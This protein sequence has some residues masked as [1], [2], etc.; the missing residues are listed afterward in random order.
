MKSFKDYLI[1]GRDAPLYHGTDFHSAALIIQT[2]KMKATNRHYDGKGN[3]VSMTRNMKY[4][5]RFPLWAGDAYDDNDVVVFEL[6]QRKLAQRYKIVSFAFD[7]GTGRS[8]AR[9]PNEM[10]EFEERVYSNIA[11]I[12]NFITKIY[13]KDFKAMKKDLERQAPDGYIPLLNNWK[14]Y[15]LKTNKF[16]NSVSKKS[17]D[18]LTALKIKN[19]KLDHAMSWE[20]G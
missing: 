8:M 1:E 4:A 3:A 6:D 14:L 11:N 15:D 7:I 18:K 17:N 13:V 9:G 16:V 10:S 19:K 5:F 20:L 2:N 12:N